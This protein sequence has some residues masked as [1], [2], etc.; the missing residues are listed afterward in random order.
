MK[1]IIYAAPRSEIKELQQVRQLLVEKYGKEFA[2]A[3]IENSDGKVA[4]RV[5]FFPPPFEVE[6]TNFFI[7]LEETSCRTPVRDSRNPVS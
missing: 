6:I 4:E 1:S 7:G 5:P 2:L 3:A